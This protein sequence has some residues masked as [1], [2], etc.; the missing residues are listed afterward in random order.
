MYDE[1]KTEELKQFLNSLYKTMIK[2]NE[3]PHRIKE[4]VEQGADPNTES[5]R[6][7]G[8]AP[9]HFVAQAG[10][11]DL[12]KFLLEQRVC[13]ETKNNKGLTPL[14]WAA[15]EGH[16]DAIA[17]LV[18]FGAN[19]EANDIDGFTPLHW[20]A[21]CMH[22]KAIDMLVSLNAD[23]KAKTNNG[24]TPFDLAASI[25]NEEVV[26]QFLSF[27]ANDGENAFYRANGNARIVLACYFSKNETL[28]DEHWL[29]ALIRL[30]KE[31]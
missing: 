13:I 3:L 1:A 6:H 22:K 11:C 9:V 30:K 2:L 7:S 20:A 5:D 8:S 12:L 26:I 24:V 16:T 21:Y 4:L 29:C 18:R 14:H 15:R 27:G 31:A 10:A 19:I 17:L 25:G 28:H 23:I